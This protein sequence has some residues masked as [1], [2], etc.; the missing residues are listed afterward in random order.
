MIKKIKLNSYSLGFTLIELMIVTTIIMLITGGGIASFLSF[1]DKQQVLNSAKE[2]QGYL[3]TA[4]TLAR[5]GETPTGCDRLIGYKVVTADAG[6]IKE[7][8]LLAVCSSGD[9]Q[10][11]VFS[12]SE[13]VTLSSDIEIT[14]LGLYGGVTGASQIDITSDSGRSYSFE[15][16]SGGEITQGGFL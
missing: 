12:L 14:F 5:V 1:N 16:S 8:S 3:R 11:D 15:V 4:Q 13:G 9:I 10:R 2:L 7:V 6:S